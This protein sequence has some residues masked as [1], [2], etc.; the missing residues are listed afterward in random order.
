MPSHGQRTFSPQ[1]SRRFSLTSQ[2]YVIKSEE[3]CKEGT[4]GHQWF[5]CAVIRGAALATGTH[6]SPLPGLVELQ[7]S[8]GSPLVKQIRS[9]DLHAMA[10]AESET[11][12]SHGIRWKPEAGGPR[13][14]S[15]AGETASQK[16]SVNCSHIAASSHMISELNCRVIGALRRLCS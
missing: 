6:C 4:V 9:T 7:A 1:S 12:R 3:H 2:G 16:P 10:V 11:D 15:G 14:Y 8:E 5:V 13:G